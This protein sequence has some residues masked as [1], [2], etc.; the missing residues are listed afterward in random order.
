MRVTMWRDKLKS[1]T[2]IEVL[3]AVSIAV[4]LLGVSIPMFSKNAKS[5][6]LANEAETVSAFYSRARNLAFHPERKEIDGYQVGGIDCNGNKCDQLAIEAISENVDPVE[7]DNLLMPNVT[8][9]IPSDII[10]DVG[11]G[12]T[13]LATTQTV[14]VYFKGNA[15]KYILIKINSAGNIDVI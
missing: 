12:K 4:M 5:Q 9:E 7:I 8:I 2:L 13:N 11:N 10:F 15:S 6:N 3:V 1:L 14:K